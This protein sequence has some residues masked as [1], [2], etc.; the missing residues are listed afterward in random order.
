M[1]CWRKPSEGERFWRGN[2]RSGI[3]NCD[4]NKHKGSQIKSEFIA[5]LKRETL[6]DMV[7]YVPI[8]TSF[9]F[10]RGHTATLTSAGASAFATVDI[11][12]H[13]RTH[14]L[15][16][17]VKYKIIVRKYTFSGI[18]TILEGASHCTVLTI[19]A[20]GSDWTL[21][22]GLIE[23]LNTWHSAPLTEYLESIWRSGTKISY[24]SM[25][26]WIICVESSNLEAE[27]TLVACYCKQ[28][29]QS[30]K[31]SGLN[32]IILIYLERRFLVETTFDV[33]ILYELWC[34]VAIYFTV[35]LV[36]FTVSL[37]FS[38]LLFASFLQFFELC[39]FFVVECTHLSVLSL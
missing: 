31:I 28:S 23:I 2:W 15:Q 26:Y 35:F 29:K 36:C 32:W 37:A 33:Q 12:L 7:A 9:I 19:M 25:I 1:C 10:I 11:S 20:P 21:S 14:H 27:R 18:N 17:H 3:W 38:Y 34:S 39:C 4:K 5:I 30:F 6:D 8:F 24:P 22:P 16:V 13:G